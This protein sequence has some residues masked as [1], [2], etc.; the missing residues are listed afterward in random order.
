MGLESCYFKNTE[1]RGS[2]A[3]KRSV[4]SKYYSPLAEQ[5]DYRDDIFKSKKIK[6]Q[7]IKK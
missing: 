6:N 1:I 5:F 7:N 4:G 2:L 3:G